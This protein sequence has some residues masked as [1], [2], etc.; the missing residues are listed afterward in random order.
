[1]NIE[2]YAPIMINWIE[3]PSEKYNGASGFSIVKSI[4][5]GNIQIRQVEYSENYLADHWCEKGHIILVTEGQL[6]VE[7]LDNSKQVVECGMT[8]LVGDQSLS[9]RASTIIATKVFI[10]D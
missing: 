6:L 9:H 10:V 5:M 2:K 7:H 3:I 1:M 8:Y 4:K